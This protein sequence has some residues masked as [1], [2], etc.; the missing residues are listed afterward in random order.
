MGDGN[1]T[2]ELNAFER[3]LDRS[4]GLVRLWGDSAPPRGQTVRQLLTIDDI[5]IW[6]VMAVEIALYLLPN[7]LASRAGRPS[8]REMLLP[9]LR[10]IKYAFQRA[11]P[12]NVSHCKSWP[13]GP[14]ALLTGFSWYLAR[15]VLLPVAERLHAGKKVAPVILTNELPENYTGHVPVQLSSRHVNQEVIENARRISALARAASS[16]LLAD[17]DYLDLFQEKG[18]PLWTKVGNAIETAL[19]IRAVRQL[20]IDISIAK[21]ILSVHRPALIASIDVA[22]PRTR[23]YSLLGRSLG[24]PTI[25]VQSGQVGN[26]AVEWRFF[27]DDLVT[28]QGPDSKRAFVSH[29]VPTERIVITGSPRYDGLT[30]ASEEERANLRR[31]F[32]ISTEAR[33]VMLASSYHT[34]YSGFKKTKELSE[35]GTL[36][37]AMKSA[38]F[39]AAELQ[40][41]LFLIIKPHPM[42]RVEETRE[43]AAGRRNMAFAE[44]SENIVQLIRACDCFMSFGSTATMEAIVLGKPTICPAYPGW[45]FSDLYT[46]SGAVLAPKSRE[47]VIASLE[48]VATDGGERIRLQCDWA[49]REF[50]ARMLKDEGRGAVENIANLMLSL[51]S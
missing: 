26:E 33:I 18:C 45:M 29:G 27:Q 2:G 43:L 47:E 38:V 41:G 35:T 6:D 3:S 40:P 21:H 49:R 17:S 13:E 14:T 7:A 46:L 23:I 12:V 51:T 48:S 24:I 4:A 34:D 15:D 9:V 5:S 1:A 50:L 28:A 25:Q 10:P 16:R 11:L 44:K 8:I 32:G 42:E 19:L 37:R 31:R 30:S 20:S 36:L 39:Q 22:D